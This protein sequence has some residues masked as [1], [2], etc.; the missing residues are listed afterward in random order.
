MPPAAAHGQAL[1]E[2]LA[3]SLVL[4][5]LFLL[6]PVIGKIQDVAHQ[7][8][9]ASRY[10][11][12]DALLRNDNHNRFKPPEQIESELRQRFFSDGGAIVTEE[13]TPAFVPRPQWSDPYA[14]PL[15]DHAEAVTLSFGPAHGKRHEDAYTA[16]SDTD[17][18]ILA[19]RA[20]LHSEGI[21]NVNVSVDLAN[22]PAGLQLIEPFDRL[23]LRIVRHASV[24]PDPWTANGPPQ[25]EERFG[26]LAP[27]NAPLEALAPLVDIVIELVENNG[28]SP[29]SFGALDRW[30]D[31]VPGDRLMAREEAQ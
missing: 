22:L 2:F 18:F 14:H 23:N 17:L 5:P 30:R 21:Y 10:A 11:A 25:A 28:V 20:G 3:L 8:Q 24:L 27:L 1:A 31:V 12:F 16:A 26:R 9:L 15:V 19:N 7:A 6:L 29:P 4:L 13:A